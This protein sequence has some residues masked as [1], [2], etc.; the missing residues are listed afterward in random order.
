MVDHDEE[1]KEALE[2]SKARIMVVGCG[3]A[4]GNTVSR[5]MESKPDDVRTIAVNTDAQD[6][7]YT[8][9][10]E[11]VLIGREVTGGRGAGND[12]SVGEEA[13]LESRENLRGR[14]SDANF[15]FVTCG[16]GG[17]TGT[18]ASPIVAD[19]AKRMDA[20]TVGV[21]TLP[22]KVE[23]ER[24]RMNAK[25]GLEKLRK[26][27]DTVVI[28]PDDNILKIAPHLPIGQAFRVADEVLINT[29]R[30]ISELITKPGLINLD[31]ADIKNVLQDDGIAKV[32]VGEAN[33]ENRSDKAVKDALDSPLLD[34]DISEAESALVN[35]RGDSDM[36]LEEAQTITKNI[37]SNLAHDA[38][39]TWGAYISDDMTDEL[40]VLVLVPNVKSPW[41]HGPQPDERKEA[42][43]DLDKK[44]KKV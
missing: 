20:L 18:G 5:F 27:V 7:L 4:G 31:F 32:G 29:I 36:T 30:G 8:D 15:V 25:N 3:G 14:I 26:A 10:D 1:L 13:A 24:R 2:K 37:S 21:V 23:G 6:L 39:I 33:G 41:A 38:Q 11:K 19:I 43:N 40:Q 12:P 16:L 17:G 22:F 28:I 44:V 42:L 35:I 34:A 9:A